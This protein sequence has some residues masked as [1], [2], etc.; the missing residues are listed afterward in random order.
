MEETNS[1]KFGKFVAQAMEQMEND[2]PEHE[3]GEVALV[4]EFQGTNESGNGTTTV[5]FMCTDPRN[6]VQ[7]GLL[8]SAVLTVEQR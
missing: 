1:S 6:H 8:H 3:L 7:L 5:R 4:C 2:F